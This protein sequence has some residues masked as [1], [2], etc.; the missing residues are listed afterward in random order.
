MDWL[1]AA[2]VTTCGLG[3]VCAAGGCRSPRSEVPPGRA[4]TNDGRQ[5]PPIGFGSDPHPAQG[6]GFTA[7]TPGTVPGR[8]G[9]AFAGPGSSPYGAPTEN[10]YGPPAYNPAGSAG[11]PLPGSPASLGVPGGSSLPP[12]SAATT[13]PAGLYPSTPPPT[14]SA[15][16]GGGGGSAARQPADPM[17]P[18]SGWPPPT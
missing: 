5:V 7:G 2:F 14:M 18:A 13:G 8:G 1:K 3:L 15:P 10:G 11:L 17:D 12:P 4:Y 16:G 6:G 9:N